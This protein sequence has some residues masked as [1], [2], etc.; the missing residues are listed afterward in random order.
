MENILNINTLNGLNFPEDYL[1]S[2]GPSTSIVKA[3]KYFTNTLKVGTVVTD[4]LIN[5]KNPLDAITLMD[6]QQWHGM[7]TFKQL[8]I[9]ETLEVSKQIEKY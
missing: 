2:T 3:E 5:G 8:E 7:L 1:L 4:G 9:K 6:E